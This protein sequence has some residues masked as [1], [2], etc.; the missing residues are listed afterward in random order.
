MQMA[1]VLLAAAALG[2]PPRR[3]RALAL[4][5]EAALRDWIANESAAR[6][7]EARRDARAAAARLEQLG[8]RVVTIADSEYPAGLRA[9]RDAPPF[10]TARG[11]MKADRREVNG[12]ESV[13][14]DTALAERG[15]IIAGQGTAIVGSRDADEEAARLAYGLAVRLAP[16][17]V[18]G[19]AR[20]IDAAAHEGALDAAAHQGALAAHERTLVDETASPG[21]PTIAYVGNGLG[22]T[23][24]P[25]HVA[26]EERIIGAGGAV[27]SE[28]LP[29]EPVTSWA[30]VK[31]DRLQAAHAAAVVLIESE[32]DGGAMRTVRFAGELGRPCFALEPRNG[33][34]YAGNRRVIEDG[35]IALPWDV[36]EI[37]RRLATPTERPRS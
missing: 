7:A 21:P 31:R 35:A 17:I 3:L 11:T 23:Y 28:R 34:R 26:L 15:S 20:G 29:D 37:C 5:D 18:S 24:P 10:L 27:V 12:T 14:D 9:L 2:V 25:E 19:L 13:D 30:L 1:L 6:L 32:I 4:G 33:A 16:P 8:A 36:D 22:A